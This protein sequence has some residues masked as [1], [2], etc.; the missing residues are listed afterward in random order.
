MTSIRTSCTWTYGEWC[1]LS[2]CQLANL[3]R[4]CGFWWLCLW[5]MRWM[6]F[7]LFFLFFLSIFFPL[8]IISENRFGIFS[9]IDRKLA[10]FFPLS[11]TIFNSYSYHCDNISDSI[12]C[13]I[14]ARIVRRVWKSIKYESTISPPPLP[15]D[16]IL[17][18]LRFIIVRVSIIDRFIN[19]SLLHDRNENRWSPWNVPMQVCVSSL[20]RKCLCCPDRHSFRD[21]DDESSVF[22]AVSKLNEVRGVKGLGRFFKQIAQSARSGG[23]DD[24]LGCV[25]IPLQVRW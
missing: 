5:T 14:V 12:K 9:A 3:A 16:C 17:L 10:D 2:S 11:F 7:P 1:R 25:N 18:I 23:Q 13:R 19:N 15:L 6:K 24:F 4:W 20:C 22:D 21:H 8:D